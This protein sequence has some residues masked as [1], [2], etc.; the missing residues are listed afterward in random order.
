MVSTTY[1]TYEQIGIREDLSDAIYDI[2]P[3]E[4]PF[5]STVRRG[6]PAKNRFIEW[7]K[8]AL[9]SA[10]AVNHAYEGEDMVALTATPTSRLRNYCQINAKGIIVSG[11]ANAVS[12]A[13]REQELAY[14][15]AKRSKEIKRDIEKQLTGNLASSAGT[16]ATTARRSAGFEAWITTNS[17]Y[18][19]TA[20]ATDGAD[21]GYTAAGTVTAATD[22]SSSNLVTFT[23]AK[24]KS[25]IALCWA[26]GGQPTTLMVGSFNKRRVSSFAGITTKFTDFNNSASSSKGLAIVGAADIYLSDFG[27][28]QVVPSRFSRDR[29]ALLIDWEYWSMHYLRPFFVQEIAK[30]G[31]AEKRQLLCEWT[32]CSKNE[33]ASGK[34]GDLTTS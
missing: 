28:L 9:A 33:G 34:H 14:Q 21:G 3:M 19:G 27:K 23:E 11:T 31:D 29:T 12:T 1:S 17:V 6:A 20:G 13:G 26:A 18:G 16:A 2:S 25:V 5:M 8:D 32:L 15:I 30:A 22:G 4:T 24:L 7:Q 10:T